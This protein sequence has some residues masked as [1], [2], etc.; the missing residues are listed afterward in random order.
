MG[1]DMKVSVIGAGNV[2]ATLAKRIVENSLADVVLLDIVKGLAEGKSLDLCH[3]GPITGGNKSI[4]GTDDYQFTKDSDIVV[5]T[6]GLARKPGMKREDLI[7]KNGDIIK[8]ITKKVVQLS[9]NAIILMVTNPLDVMTYIAYKESG[10]DAKKV[11]GMAGVLDS[12]RFTHLIAEELNISNA[13]IETIVLGGHGDTMVPLLSQTKISNKPLFKFLSLSKIQELVEKT[14][15]AGAK[16]V[17][18]LGSGSAYYAPSAASFLMVRAIIKDEKRLV[19]ASCYLNGEYG[20]NDLCLGVP[21]RLGSRGI[22]EVIELDITEEEK[23]ALQ[24]SAETTRRQIE[25]YLNK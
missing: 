7:F 10:F 21:V 8:D 11:I 24:K 22:E 12:S 6:A 25:I 9:P 14:R 23:K 4:C 18:L 15:K 13:A 19:P 2:G 20:F 5:I 17:S 1:S 3:A 16:I